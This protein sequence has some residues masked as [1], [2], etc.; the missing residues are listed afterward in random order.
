MQKGE[1]KSF[2]FKKEREGRLMFRH[3][4]NVSKMKKYFYGIGRLGKKSR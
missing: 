1:N 4:S 3:V 2:M